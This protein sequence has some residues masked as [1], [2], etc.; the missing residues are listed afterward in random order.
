MASQLRWS[1]HV[2]RIRDD[3]VPKA[4]TFELLEEDRRSRGD[5][6]KRYK[7]ALKMTMKACNIDPATSEGRG[8]EPVKMV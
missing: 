5:Q 8:S 4:L 3:G 1:G 2:A 6:R 7:D